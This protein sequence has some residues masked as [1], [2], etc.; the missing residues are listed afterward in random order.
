MSVS[1]KVISVLVALSLLISD[2][3]AA[4]AMH[5]HRYEAAVA[6]Q[7]TAPE[8][9]AHALKQLSD[10]GYARATEQLAYL[11]L[12]GRGV[13]QDTDAAIALYQKAVAGGRASSMVSLAKAYLTTGEYQTAIRTLNQASKLGLIKADAVLAWAHATNRLGQYSM[14]ETGFSQLVAL[15]NNGARDGQLNLL[16]AA[17][18]IGKAP[19]NI[20]SVLHQLHTRHSEGDPKA[21]EV[22]LKYYRTVGHP[23]GTLAVRKTLLETKGLREKVRVEEGLHL[24]GALQPRHFWTEAEQLV[25]SAPA[26][27]YARALVVT[28]KINKNAYVRIVQKELRNLGYPVGIASPFMNAPLIRSINMFC[29]ERNIAGACT[30]GPLKSTTVKAVASELASTRAPT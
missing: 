8:R 4:D 29:R 17:V 23:T 1:S 30:L 11:T 27:V 13:A 24:A 2:R 28:A 16:D 3:A 19:P 5:K 7:A 10:D 15:S 12:K 21:A 6:F 20:A 9:T 26:H 25:D 14:P 22:L 18:R